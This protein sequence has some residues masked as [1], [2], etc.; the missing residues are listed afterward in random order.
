MSSFNLLYNP[1]VGAIIIPILW[2]RKGKKVTWPKSDIQEE[3]EKR[4]EYLVQFF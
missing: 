2:M 3:R 1:E 4:F